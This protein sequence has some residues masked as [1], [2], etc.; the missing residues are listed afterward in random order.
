MDDVKRS[1]L[2]RL[3][4][5]VMNTEVRGLLRRRKTLV[6]DG[7]GATLCGFVF[8]PLHQLAVAY[9]APDAGAFARLAAAAQDADLP[10]DQLELHAPSDVVQGWA[11]TGLAEPGWLAH[12]FRWDPRHETGLD[13]LVRHEARMVEADDDALHTLPGSLRRELAGQEDFPVC[14]ASL[15]GDSIASLV[16]AFVETEAY[17]DVSIDTLA[18]FRRE[19]FATSSAAFLIQRQLARGLRPVWGASATNEASMRL[20]ARLGFEREG[21]IRTASVTLREND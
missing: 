12:I 1:L 8:A 20:A 11:A 14:A 4:D 16:Y 5:D 19:G 10:L 3:P 21:E 9:G 18:D 15:A 2:E 6:I 13:A 17:W 7:D